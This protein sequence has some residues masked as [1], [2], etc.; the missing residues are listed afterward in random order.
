MLLCYLHIS[1]QRQQVA[2]LKA[3][4][5]YNT[6]LA[7]MQHVKRESDSTKKF[8]KKTCSY[9]SVVEKVIRGKDAYLPCTRNVFCF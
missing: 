2:M 4:L 3:T 5:E 7:R 1:G 8:T 9:R 6:S